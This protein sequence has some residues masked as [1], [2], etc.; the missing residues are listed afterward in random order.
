MAKRTFRPL[1]RKPTQKIPLPIYFCPHGES[2]KYWANRSQ[3]NEGG[4]GVRWWQ[5]A[6]FPCCSHSF[7]HHTLWRRELG[8]TLQTEQGQWSHPAYHGSLGGKG[9]SGFPNALQKAEI[10][11]IRVPRLW[12][13]LEHSAELTKQPKF[14]LFMGHSWDPS[15]GQIH[16]SGIAEPLTV[17]GPARLP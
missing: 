13:L 9:R 14:Q 1:W 5:W 7:I 2:T 4:G 17:K 15:Q 11:S 8:W 12:D 16:H 3:R 6:V 10:Y